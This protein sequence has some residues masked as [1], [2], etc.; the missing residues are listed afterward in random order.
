MMKLPGLLVL[1]AA[2]PS[3]LA[4]QDKAPLSAS[5]DLGFVNTAGNSSVTTFNAGDKI[6]YTTDAWSLSQSFS[7][8]YGRTGDSTNASQW[9]AG[10]RAEYAF[11]PRVGAFAMGNF[12]RNTFAGFVWHFEEAAGLAVTAVKDSMNLLQAELGLSVNQ[13]RSTTDSTD[14][15]VAA[16]VAATYR[17]NLTASA[18]VQEIAEFLPDLKDTKDIRVNSETSLVAPIS[19]HIAVKLAYAVRFDNVPEPGFKKTDRVFTSGLQIAF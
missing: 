9:K 1:V 2:A 15:F 16:R 3:L 11:G 8:I 7:A 14:K 6:K 18:Y 5:V 4:A 10:L 17:R 13:Q 19:S 12:E